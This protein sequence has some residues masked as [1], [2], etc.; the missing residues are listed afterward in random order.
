MSEMSL[1][2]L[3][4]LYKTQF[5]I[6]QKYTLEHKY[7]LGAGLESYNKDIFK[8]TEIT[9][10]S[11]VSERLSAGNQVNIL[12]VGCGVGNAARDLVRKF[13]FADNLIID[14]I[15]A[16]DPRSEEERKFDKARNIKF[17]DG[18]LLTYNFEGAKYDF[19]FSHMCIFHLV[20]PLM[21]IKRIHNNL[22]K[23]NGELY[24]DYRMYQMAIK[25]QDRK[26]GV[27][28]LVSLWQKRQLK[29]EFTDDH[30]YLKKGSNNM[31]RIGLH[32]VV[33]PNGHINYQ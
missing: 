12:F 6:A 5:S 19:I 15:S 27:E 21:A 14:E 2:Y 16:G 20:D 18:N 23:P 13:N 26:A 24:S 31:S 33:N 29:V 11:L 25:F 4:S 32:Y 8:T 3:R 22:L 30:L 17:I 7:N 28:R 9:I 10:Q 1:D